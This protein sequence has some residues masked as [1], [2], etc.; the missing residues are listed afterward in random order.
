MSRIRTTLVAV[1]AAGLLLMSVG[2]AHADIVH[3]DD[4]VV[5]PANHTVGVNQDDLTKYWL[6]SEPVG[7][8]GEK[9]CN[10]T[11][12]SPAHVTFNLPANVTADKD[13]LVFTDCSASVAQTVNF[14]ADEPG[15]YPISVSV[16]DNGVGTYR[17]ADADFILHVIDN[18]Q[19]VLPNLPDITVQATSPS[20]AEVSYG[21]ENAVDDVDGNVPVVFT[22]A[23]PHTFSIGIHT[24]SYTATDEAGNEAD[25]RSFQVTVTEPPAPPVDSTPPVITVSADITKEATGPSG[26]V[27]NYT[28]SVSDNED[29]NP[30]LTCTPASGSTFGLGET[31]VTCTATDAH[32]NSASASFKVTVEDTTPPAVT[33]PADVI[34]EAT[35]PSGAAVNFSGSSATDIV[36]GPLS[37]S[38]SPVSGSTFGLGENTVTVSATDAHNNTGTVTF[39]VTVQDTTAPALTVPANITV[40]A[41]SNSQAVVTFAATATDLVD[42]NVPVT[43]N[44][45]SGSS[46][47]V[48]L[49]SVTC[50]ATDAHTNTA[51]ASFTVRVNYS[52]N[53]FFQPI[54]NGDVVNKAKAGQSIPVKF[55]LGGNQG[56][57][58]MTAGY[59]NFVFGN[60]PSADTTDEVESYATSSTPGLTYDAAANQYV[61]VWKTD[62]AWAGKSGTLRIKLADGSMHTAMFNFTK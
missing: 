3:Q 30:S 9:N 8:D 6:T 42:G 62:K 33:A 14:K 58:I 38:Y 4:L 31:T 59:P 21:P 34:A 48:G 43:C 17:T 41:T 40:N 55:S 5:D 27:V 56:L 61:Y 36:D 26:A 37:V 47:P 19:P 54:D 20:G 24:V 15:D 44:P 39:K 51:T 23:S 32:G 10:A 2:V 11:L 18:K 60:V 13:E 50:T 7:Q 28:V 12:A 57:N 16:T 22:P 35:G 45:A 52:W 53:G 29:P 49:T 25:A 1:L 46:F